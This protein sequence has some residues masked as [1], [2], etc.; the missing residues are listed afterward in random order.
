MLYLLVEKQTE[1]KAGAA[2]A[3][4]NAPLCAYGQQPAWV[5]KVNA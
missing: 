3:N 4:T 2:S 5:K 1:K